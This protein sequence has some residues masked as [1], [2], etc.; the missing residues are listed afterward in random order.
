M[1]VE[2][3]IYYWILGLPSGCRLTLSISWYEGWARRWT[4]ATISKWIRQ[5]T[6]ESRDII[7]RRLTNWCSVNEIRKPFYTKLFLFL[8]KHETY[9]VHKIT[10]ARTVWA[11]N[12]GKRF[13]GADNLPT[14]VWLE[15]LYF[16]VFKVAHLASRGVFNPVPKQKTAIA[17]SSKTSYMFQQQTAANFTGRQTTNDPSRQPKQPLVNE[18]IPPY[19]GRRIARQKRRR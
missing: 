10:F 2:K 12:G 5:Q 18:R 16:N 4:F 9:C 13:Q 3:C 14:P 6:K 1:H 8:S 11:N 15:V 19:L 7:P 17:A